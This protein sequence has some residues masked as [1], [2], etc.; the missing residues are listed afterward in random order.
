MPAS[1]PD[2]YDSLTDRERELL[3]LAVEGHSNAEIA[4][5]LYIS[6]RTAETHR[7]RMMRKL[8]LATQVELV[9]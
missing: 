5:R 4:R 8:N 3:Q 9:R 2:P 7:Q 1:P 6:K